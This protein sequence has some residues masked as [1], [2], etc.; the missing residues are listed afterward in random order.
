MTKWSCKGSLGS[1][2]LRDTNFLVRRQYINDREDLRT[3][4]SVNQV[5]SFGYWEE[6]PNRLLIQDAV[7]NA[8]A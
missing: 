8:E 2:G 3:L 4:S 1:V 7:V 6:V 5:F